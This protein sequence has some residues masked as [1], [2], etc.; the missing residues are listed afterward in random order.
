MK[1]IYAMALLVLG[2]CACFNRPTVEGMW[3]QP[4][5]GMEEQMQGIRLEKDGKAVSVN[6]ATLQYESWKLENNKLVLSGK[7]IGNGQT[8][9]FSEAY[10]IEKLTEKELILRD[11]DIQLVYRRDQAK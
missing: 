3:L 8:I 2:L 1:K 7:S 9:E 11:G 6:M 10:K 4:I 5:P